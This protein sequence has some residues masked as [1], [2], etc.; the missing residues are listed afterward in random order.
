MLSFPSGCWYKTEQ[1]GEHTLSLRF[2][3]PLS[4]YSSITKNGYMWNATYAYVHSWLNIYMSQQPILLAY[5]QTKSSQTRFSYHSISQWQEKDK[6]PEYLDYKRL[7]R[8]HSNAVG[9]PWLDPGSK[10]TTLKGIWG[11]T[12]CV[13]DIRDYSFLRCDNSIVVKRSLFSGGI[14]WSNW[15]KGSQRLQLTVKWLWKKN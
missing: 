3:S 1:P 6:K 15:G 11:T 12:D 2:K 10:I 5:L 7:K 4:T 13:L 14:C 8:Y 9:C